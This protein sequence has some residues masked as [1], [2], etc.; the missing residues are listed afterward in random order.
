MYVYE[1]R[2]IRP[3]DAENTVKK[4]G[5]V[6]TV[7]VHFAQHRM[8]GRV[9]FTFPLLP[10]LHLA[11]HRFPNRWH[12]HEIHHELKAPDGVWKLELG[13]FRQMDVSIQIC[14]VKSTSDG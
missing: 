13:N 6:V 7:H 14:R 3:R 9:H 2:K 1:N 12:K 8:F 11:M 5:E 10:R 4:K